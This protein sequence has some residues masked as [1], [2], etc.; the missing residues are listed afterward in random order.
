MRYRVYLWKSITSQEAEVLREVQAADADIAIKQV[1]A[2]VQWPYAYYA[3]VVPDDDEVSCVI[4]IACAVRRL[5]ALVTKRGGSWKKAKISASIPTSGVPFVCSCLPPLN[6]ALLLLPLVGVVM[7]VTACASSG[8]MVPSIAGSVGS[9]STTKTTC[10]SDGCKVSS[11]VLSCVCVMRCVF[12]S[13]VGLSCAVCERLCVV[14]SILQEVC[15]C[16]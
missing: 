4:A 15:V 7:L 11:C 5:V 1:M 6:L 8:A 13:L 2:A 14:F 3:W 16:Q 12:S 10:L 9:R